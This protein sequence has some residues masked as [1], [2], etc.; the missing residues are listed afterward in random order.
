MHVKR[1]RLVSVAGRPGLISVVL[2]YSSL[3]QPTQQPLGTLKGDRERERRKNNVRNNIYYF[4]CRCRERDFL[5]K[6]HEC[7][8]R[9]GK[10]HTYV[11]LNYFIYH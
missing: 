3:N 1:V 10:V 7:L 8:E 5:K 9:D 11:R 6:L 4:V 2:T